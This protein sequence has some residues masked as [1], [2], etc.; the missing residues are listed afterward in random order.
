ML[1]D[2]LKDINPDLS[3]NFYEEDETDILARYKG[4][5]VIFRMITE[6]RVDPEAYF[7]ELH[8]PNGEKLLT[9]EDYDTYNGALRGIETYKADVLKDNL[10]IILS[11]K[12]EYF[13]KLLSGKNLLLCMGERYATKTRCQAAIQATKR[14]ANTAIFDENFEDH[15]VRVP[16]EDTLPIPPQD[17]KDGKWVIDRSIS[18]DGEEFYFFELY[19]KNG[20]R[21]L[22]SE[23]YTTYIGAVNGIQTHKDNIKKGNFRVSLTKDGDYTYK[24]LNSNKQ[25]LC[26]GERYRTKQRCLNAVESVKRYALYSPVLTNPTFLK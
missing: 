11:K 23:E 7:F 2:E 1:H 5:W 26:L 22:A 17:G 8:A 3:I 19:A 12:G 4:K 13:F 9:S 10:R 25:L 15:V 24:L 21:L 18:K 6:D 16:R 20:E 14:F